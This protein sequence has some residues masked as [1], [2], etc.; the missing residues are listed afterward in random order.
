MPHML[1]LGQGYTASRLAARL[2][3]EGWHVTGIR[4]AADAEALAFDDESAVRAAIAQ[5]SH[6]LSSVPPEGDADPVLARHGSAIAAAPAL[7]AGYLSSTG[8]YGAA[9]G[10]WGDDATPLPPGRP[11]QNND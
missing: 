1:I 2:R 3:A 11:N 7:W 9:A 5:A 10:A 4:R 6:I 8:V